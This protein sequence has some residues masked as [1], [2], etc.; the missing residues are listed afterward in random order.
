MVTQVEQHDGPDWPLRPWLYAV[1]A[2]LGGY[3]FYRLTNHNY[4]EPLTVLRQAGATF[5]A[6][7]T[8][9][10]LLTFEYRRWWWSLAFALG[11]GLVVAFVGW[12]TARYNYVPTIFE[13]PYFAGLFAVVVAAPLFQAAR[14][15][16]AWRFPFDALHR[17]AWG[18]AA[19]YAAAS[20]FTGLS[21]LLFF[22]FSQLFQTIG[23]TLLRDLIDKEWFAWVFSGLAF[24]GA[25]GILRERDSLL[26]TVRRLVMAVLS[27]LAPMVA[28]ALGAFLLSMI[29]T[30]L[31]PF[32]K[33]GIPPTPL[34]LT[35]AAFAFALIN[36]VIG[37][38]HDG[39]PRKVLLYSAAV[40]AF[41]IVPLAVLAA[42]SLGQRIGQYGWTPERIWGVIAIGAALVYGA[43]AW[44]SL[45]RRKLGF[46][47]TLRP[48][49]VH[50]SLGLVAIA[51]FLALPIVD[52]GAISARS[53]I[54]RLEHGKVGV[55]EF[56]WTAMAF[57]FGSSGRKY[58]SQF[59]KRGGESGRLATE[60]LKLKNRYEVEVL[61]AGSNDELAKVRDKVILRSPGLK[62]NDDIARTMSQ[63]TN[64]KDS[65]MQ[66]A[67]VKLDDNRIVVI[68]QNRKSSDY[69]TAEVLSV[70][71]HKP[72]SPAIERPGLV[73]L[74]AVPIEIRPITRQQI[75]VNGKPVGEPIE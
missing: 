13:W 53:Q 9:S 39:P 66:C 22:L 5:V 70:A 71:D 8:L 30:G 47:E 12:T 34:L 3:L 4:E 75:Y 65:E 20:A 15:E 68:S 36:V 57:N 55:S 52:F 61:V 69:T 6:V 48:L 49:Q 51:V 18:D 19:I 29:F 44:W 16:G 63:R 43:I 41:V 74:K 7:V 10:L 28:A 11:W 56:D 46:A 17:H 45:L 64:C 24:G 38:G 50:Y 42:L 14:D 26:G 37:D 2:A 25:V 72:D 1:G 73:D 32:W 35:S 33:S 40:L 27:V 59:A 62:W 23:I 60:A 58:L 54:A 21:F 67:V 31:E